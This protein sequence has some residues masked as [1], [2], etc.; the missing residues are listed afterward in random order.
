VI[1]EER[2][3]EEREVIAVRETIVVLRKLKKVRVL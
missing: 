1:G 2:Q 3:E